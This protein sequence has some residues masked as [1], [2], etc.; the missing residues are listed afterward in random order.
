MCFCVA[1]CTTTPCMLKGA[2]EHVK[3]IEKKLGIHVGETSKDGLFTLSEVE[4]LGACVH[5]PMMA[6]N[7]DYYED[8]QLKDTEEILNECKAGK[9]PFPGPRSGRLAA[10]PITGLTTL[11]GTP[12]GPGFG[13]R[14]DL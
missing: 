9:K 6:I 1:V 7:D 10:E 12:T 2:E 4:C 3:Y 5:A 11:T 13:L 8:L 14:K